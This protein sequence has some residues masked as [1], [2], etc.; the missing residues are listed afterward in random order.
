MLFTFNSFWKVLLGNMAV[1]IFYNYAGFQITTV[2]L[3]STLLIMST[4]NR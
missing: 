3:L 2:L 1:L 4:N